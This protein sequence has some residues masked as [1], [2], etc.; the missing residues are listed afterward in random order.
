MVYMYKGPLRDAVG[1]KAGGCRKLKRGR[2]TVLM[3]MSAARFTTMN[4]VVPLLY[5][6]GA[7]EIQRKCGLELC[8]VVFRMARPHHTHI[9]T[10]TAHTERH[11]SYSPCRPLSPFCFRLITFLIQRTEQKIEL[12]HDRQ[13]R[14]DH[15]SYFSY[16]CSFTTIK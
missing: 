7:F 14:E 15:I 2:N 16:F 3:C 13:G 4:S 6:A 10:H 1:V 12:R 11:R 8:L 5:R 9:R